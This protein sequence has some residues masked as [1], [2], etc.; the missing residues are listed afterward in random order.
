MDTHS[1]AIHADNPVIG[2]NLKAEDGG[3]SGWSKVEEGA[4][5]R[6]WGSKG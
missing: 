1:G 5:K 2:T 3:K 6:S 4:V